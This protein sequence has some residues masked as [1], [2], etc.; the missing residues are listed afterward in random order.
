MFITITILETSFL[1]VIIRPTEIVQN[2]FCIQYLY[3]DLSFQE[4][5]IGTPLLQKNK[6]MFYIIGQQST[7][8]QHNFMKSYHD[9]ETMST[10]P[11]SLPVTYIKLLDF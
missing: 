2:W 11:Q 1:L 5:V 8:I 7:V 6:Y 9:I 3:M 10:A 4:V